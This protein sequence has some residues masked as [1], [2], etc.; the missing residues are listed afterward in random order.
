MIHIKPTA[1]PAD[2]YRF[3]SNFIR[4]FRDVN[5][6]NEKST[7][8]TLTEGV[9]AEGGIIETCMTVSDQVTEIVARHTK[10][11]R[12]EVMEY[13]KKVAGQLKIPL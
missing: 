5:A 9:S 7:L 3:R 4:F 6:G 1:D 2:V 11:C 12:T 8:P 13:L 10:A